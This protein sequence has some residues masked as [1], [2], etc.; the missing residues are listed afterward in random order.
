MVW[1]CERSVS[2]YRVVD[3]GADDETLLAAT[4][5]LNGDDVSGLREHCELDRRCMSMPGEMA[6]YGSTTGR[7]GTIG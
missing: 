2:T 4:R 3:V 7:V 6:G 1:D 5:V